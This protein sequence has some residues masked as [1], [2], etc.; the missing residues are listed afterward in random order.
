LKVLELLRELQE[1]GIR[2]RADD[3][4]RL[5]VRAPKGA[6][7]DELAGRV[8]AMKPELLELLRDN[9]TP[10]QSVEP[11][12]GLADMSQPPLSPAQERIWAL[13]QMDPASTVYN[14]PGGFRLQGP[15]DRD[16]L[17]GA[18][19][20]IV[21][22]HAV[23][24][25]RFKPVNG[26][27]VLELA[28]RV[29]VEMPVT[30]LSSVAEADR[31]TAM[32]DF[33]ETRADEP[34]DLEAGPPF[35]VELARLADEDHALLFV[36]HAL[37]WDG[38]SFDT[39]L[40]ELKA[41]YEA[42]LQGNDRAMAPLP[43]QY[44][45][46]A[47]WQQRRFHR[48]DLQP[49]LAYWR[50]KLRG[51][52]PSMDLPTD[53]PRMA[54]TDYR[55]ARQWFRLEGEVLEAVR[56]L[57]RIENATPYVIFLAALDVL[58]HRYSGARDIV[59][60]TPLQCRTHP[61]VEDLIGVFVN[62][63][64]IRG[65][66]DPDATFRSLL[67]QLRATCWEAL[68]HQEAPS[69][70]VVEGMEDDGLDHAPYEVIFVYQQ[71]AAR[72]TEMGPIRVH[73]I[74]RGTRKVAVD[75][76][77]WAREYDAYVDG[78]FDYRTCLFDEARMARMVEHFKRVIEVGVQ[79]PDVPVGDLDILDPRESE[80][81]A[82]WGETEAEAPRDDGSSPLAMGELRVG[83]LRLSAADARE[84]VD[85]IAAELRRRER[86]SGSGATVAVRLDGSIV[87]I[88][89][90]V[91][92]AEEKRDT[93]LVH[94]DL[95]GD[96]LAAQL[97]GAGV[98]L[99]IA[100]DDLPANEVPTDVSLLEPD[101][102]AGA[103]EATEVEST[104]VP[105][106]GSVLVSVPDSGGGT[107]LVER[108]WDAFFEDVSLLWK[109]LALATDNGVVVYPD[110]P[111]EYTAA[112]I[113]AAAGAGSTL[114]LPEPGAPPDG[115]E[116]EELLSKSEVSAAL[117]GSRSFGDLVATGWEAK[118]DVALTT[119]PF[120]SSTLEAALRDR[121]RRFV[122]VWGT[123]EGGATAL[124]GEGS[125]DEE[126]VGRPGG[127]AR[128]RIVDRRGRPVPVGVEGEIVIAGPSVA[129]GYRDDPAATAARFVV[130]PFD[131]D[132]RAFRTGQL[133]RWSDGGNI[134]PGGRLDRQW[135]L[136]G[137]RFDLTEVETVIRQ[138]P[139][140]DDVHAA[141]RPVDGERHLVAYLATTDD[142]D[143]AAMIRGD[144]AA[145]L[146]PWAIPSRLLPVSSIP[147]SASGAVNE[148]K[149]LALTREEG[150]GFVAPRS[151]EE[152]AL[153]EAWRDALGLDRVGIHDNFFELGGHSL[154]A[155]Q[156]SR[157]L[158]D[159]LGLRIDPRSLFFH[160]LEQ[161]AKGAVR[162]AGATA[163]ATNK[164]S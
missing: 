112:A 83:E 68:D 150:D 22:R 12:D 33:L 36:A 35:R 126:G 147:R 123:P 139:S 6:M 89:G 129:A 11:L 3:D 141:I 18:L 41:H 34:L 79:N 71:T 62:T 156:V 138:H 107:L 132:V 116:L 37:V 26:E 45:D 58:I 131:A 61:A 162:H 110:G 38:W 80:R 65:A 67:Q 47:E 40:Q 158:E 56:E 137:P 164:A 102:A 104:A 117:A 55:G 145:H 87:S 125:L 160:T 93:L 133:A 121:A 84:T 105:T 149:L 152:R 92:V 144:L 19:Q 136:D 60:A 49:H 2:L 98:D 122:R 118:V 82:A 159:G 66:V 157:T 43:V 111:V 74:M 23:L 51:P 10:G 155:V 163:S 1:R 99:L 161:V 95:R 134:L 115:W 124:L 25:S 53:R 63:L 44:V 90:L 46:F 4:G 114:V 100:G 146:P 154:L 5:V 54:A 70:L 39:L 76:V 128:I 42:L 9:A 140:V 153:A 7:D 106:H 119:D 88:A 31:D 151:D 109:E 13:Q 8:R 86:S 108:S 127:S 113:L 135:T 32:R 27:P 94:P 148:R 15:L 48:G 21:D 75:L 85:V 81:L 30:D 64:F 91:A 77:V 16:A 59:V 17:T 101:T 28:E 72:P 120:L 50:D 52:L 20:A 96:L 142:A 103:A 73:S 14:H 97:R 29:K 143:G 57:A 24:R 69:E 78:G 130:D